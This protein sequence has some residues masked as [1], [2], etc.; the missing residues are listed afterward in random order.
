MLPA[1]ELHDQLRLTAAEVDDVWA[2][3]HLARELHAKEPAISQASPDTALCIGL[4][5]TQT[6]REVSR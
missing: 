2:D 1:V 4:S 5:A 3:R 6:A